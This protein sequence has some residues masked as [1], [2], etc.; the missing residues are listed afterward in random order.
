MV[1]IPGCY[2]AGGGNAEELRQ[3]ES[4]PS[5]G[6]SSQLASRVRTRQGYWRGEPAITHVMNHEGRVHFNWLFIDIEEMRAK[7][8]QG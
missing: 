5:R 3:R 4:L 1:C 6:I 2:S 8:K 7:S